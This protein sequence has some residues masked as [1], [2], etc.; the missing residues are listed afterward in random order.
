M[1]AV[2]LALLLLVVCNQTASAGE[3]HASNVAYADGVYRLAFDVVIDAELDAVL[4][5]VTDYERLERLSE[6]LIES[7][8][9]E[10]PAGAPLRRMLVARTCLLI[11]CRSLRVVEDIEAAENVIVTTIV[12]EQ[13][14]FRSGGTR[15]VLT[16]LDE[17]R[18]RIEFT[19]VEEPDFWIPPVL[20]PLLVKRRL[21]KEARLV[22]SNIEAAAAHD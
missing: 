19:G 9:I 11:F 20:G 4:A 18:C 15:W 10:T 12:P 22:I 6:M 2:R 16:A 13:S 7:T 14:D 8:L 1:P 17:R 5:I 3:V 21:L